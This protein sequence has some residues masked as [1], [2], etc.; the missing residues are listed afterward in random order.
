MVSSFDEIKKAKKRAVHFAGEFTPCTE[1]LPDW[2][3]V[4][5]PGRYVF[6]ENYILMRPNRIMS[7]RDHIRMHTSGKWTRTDSLLWLD[8]FARAINSHI[9]A[10]RVAGDKAFR[11][12][13]MFFQQELFFDPMKL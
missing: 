7:E 13:L 2:A 8:C 3:A 10:N 5:P 11:S 6:F 12:V 9:D 4:V 1:L